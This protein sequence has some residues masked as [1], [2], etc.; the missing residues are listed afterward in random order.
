LGTAVQLFI[1]RAQTVRPISLTDEN[2]AMIADICV[3]IDGLPLA[4]EL[5]TARINLFSPES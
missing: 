1:E 2:S 3:R 5:A 4:I